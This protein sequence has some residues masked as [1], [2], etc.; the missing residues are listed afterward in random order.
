MTVSNDGAPRGS[1][2]SPARRYR[3]D[4]AWTNHVEVEPVVGDR[5]LTGVHWWDPDRIAHV[6]D[7][8]EFCPACGKALDGP[9]SLAV[10]YWEGENR[11]F[12]TRCGE[13]GWSGDITRIERMIGHEAPHD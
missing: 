2:L 5:R 6:S 9:G 4:P 7:H 12:H 1:S 3:R 11:T 10:E 8:P 13:C